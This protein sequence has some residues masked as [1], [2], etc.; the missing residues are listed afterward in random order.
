MSDA[1]I[2]VV[3]K[4]LGFSEERVTGC[5]LA[6]LAAQLLKTCL[7]TL[8]GVGHVARGLS[9]LK[10]PLKVSKPG[11]LFVRNLLASRGK[12]QLFCAASWI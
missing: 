4:L 10:L 1:G 3:L 8:V 7:E 2:Q 6:E 11:P 9:A 12:D 5:N